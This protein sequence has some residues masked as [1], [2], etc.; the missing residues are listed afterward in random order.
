MNRSLYRTL[1]FG[2]NQLGGLPKQLAALP[3]PAALPMPLLTLTGEPT[4]VMG[5]PAA[6]AAAAV[7]ADMPPVRPMLGMR[8]VSDVWLLVASGPLP[9]LLKPAMLRENCCCC[10]LPECWL[11]L[12]KLNMAAG[13]GSL[14]RCCGRCGLAK[15]FCMGCC[16]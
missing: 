1:D 14:C 8:L 11:L 7:P 13:H 9:L 6:A 2:E 15:V 10:W 16:C 4:G 3:G 12:G 5:S